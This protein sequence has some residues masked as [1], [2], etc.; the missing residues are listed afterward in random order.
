MAMRISTGL[1]NFMLSNG[2]LKRAMQGGVIKIY[3]G[4]QPTSPNDTVPSSSTLLVTLTLASGAITAETIPEGSVNLDSGGSGSVDTITVN[5]ED[6]LGAAVD[7]DSDL[8]TTATAVAAQINKFLSKGTAEFVA[9]TDG[10]KVIL[11]AVP[12]SGDYSAAV[13]STSTTIATTDVAVGTETSGVDSA[14]GL[15]YGVASSGAIAKASGVWSGVGAASGT[16]GWFRHYGPE[17]DAGGAST[18]KNRIDGTCGTSG[19]DM[20]MSSTAI[21]SGATQTLDSFSLTLPMAA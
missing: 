21:T 10:A 8:S 1:R 9:S 11:T 2:P 4:A 5:G 20:N 17:S 16:A 19:A 13:S 15:T 18:T 12:N 14:N 6:I 3:S 7:F